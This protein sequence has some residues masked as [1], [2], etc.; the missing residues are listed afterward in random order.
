MRVMF[1]FSVVLDV[2]QKALTS[3]SMDS[4]YLAL[5]KCTFLC[6]EF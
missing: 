4:R 1:V 6:L 5:I 3:C 2:G